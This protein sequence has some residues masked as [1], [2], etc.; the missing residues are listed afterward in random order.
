[1]LS[2]ACPVAKAEARAF[3]MPS[4][5][6]D[7][8]DVAIANGFKE[9]NLIVCD[10]NPAIVA[11]L[12]RRYPLIQTVGIELARLSERV[13][14]RSVHVANFDLCG[15]VSKSLIDQVR[16]ASV[17]LGR[18]S[19]A[20]VTVLRGRELSFDQKVEE[21]EQWREEL[22]S[23][24]ASQNLYDF[25]YLSPQ[26]R[27]RVDDVGMALFQS[28]RYQDRNM[29]IDP[30]RVFSYRSPSRVSTM[31]VSIWAFHE[32]EMTETPREYFQRMVMF[33]EIH[34]R[35]SGLSTANELREKMRERLGRLAA[36]T[37]DAVVSKL[38]A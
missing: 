25:S 12:K 37:G 34:D 38:R 29:W 6:G 20:A 5:E 15:C 4:I 11:T 8:I 18:N 7:E 16:C 22:R 26:D 36:T 24:G 23:G 17:V 10:S 9:K 21:S 27:A 28:L 13:K 35:Y 30:L 3:L 19:V 32:K 1:V 31:L 33:R 14:D 2:E